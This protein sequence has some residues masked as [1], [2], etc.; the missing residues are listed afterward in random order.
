[1]PNRRIEAE[2]EGYVIISQ[3][4]AFLS[5]ADRVALEE[6]QPPPLLPLPPPE[7]PSASSAAHETPASAPAADDGEVDEWCKRHQQEAEEY[8]R[9]MQEEPVDPESGDEGQER[10]QIERQPTPAEVWDGAVTLD[11][12]FRIRAGMQRAVLPMYG[13][14]QPP[15]PGAPSIL[16][17]LRP[18]AGDQGPDPAT[19]EDEREEGEEAD[20][21]EES[22]GGEEEGD[23]E[24]GEGQE[25]RPVDGQDGI[26]H[27]GVREVECVGPVE[28]GRLFEFERCQGVRQ[29]EPGS[30]SPS[31][32]AAGQGEASD[33]SSP[34]M[35][36]AA[37]SAASSPQMPL[38]LLPSQ[39][40]AA[41]QTA[42]PAAMSQA[43]RA[44][45]AAFRPAGRYM[46]R[47]PDNNREA[48][49][50]LIEGHCDG[51]R[52]MLKGV[53][54]NAIRHVDEAIRPRISGRLRAEAEANEA[55]KGVT[56]EG[57][58][59]VT[60]EL[61]AH[62]LVHGDAQRSVAIMDGDWQAYRDGGYDSVMRPWTP[63]RRVQAEIE[64]YVIISQY[65]AFLS[66]ADR[67]ALEE[68][69]PP[70]LP[71]SPPP[72]APTASSAAHETPASAPAADDG[73]VDEWCKRYRQEVEEQERIM[74]EYMAE[75]ADVLGPD[76]LEEEPVDPESG[77]EGQE[78]QEIERK[79]TPAEVWDG[80]V[81]LQDLFHIRAGKQH[82]QYEPTA[83]RHRLQRIS[84]TLERLQLP[85][86]AY[87]GS[88]QWIDFEMARR[89]PE[90]EQPLPSLPPTPGEVD[91]APVPAPHA[92]PDAL[93]K[94]ADTIKAVISRTAT[95]SSSTLRLPF[96]TAADTYSVCSLSAA[97]LIAPHMDH[98]DGSDANA[99][100]YEEAGA[101]FVDLYDRHFKA[102]VEGETDAVTAAA[103]AAIRGADMSALA[104]LQ[105]LSG[106]G[107][108]DRHKWLLGAVQSRL[109]T[110]AAAD[111]PD[112]RASA[113]ASR[114][115]PAARRLCA[116]IAGCHSRGGVGARRRQRPRD[117]GQ[118]PATSP[119]S[120]TQVSRSSPPFY[121]CR[122]FPSCLRTHYR[123]RLRDQ[124]IDFEMA[125]R[126]SETQQPLFS[127]PSTP[128]DVDLAPVPGPHA[129]P[130]ALR[131][132]AATIEA[133]I[134]RTATTSSTTVATT[135]ALRLPFSEGPVCS[136][137]A[138]LLIAP[139]MDH[140]DGSSANTEIY[141]E[142]GAFFVESRD[143][144]A[145]YDRHFADEVVRE[146]K[147]MRTATLGGDNALASLQALSGSGPADRHKWLLGAVQ[148]RLQWEQ[149]LGEAG[150]ME[151]VKDLTM[152]KL[153][154]EEGMSLR[155]VAYILYLPA[156]FPRVSAHTIEKAWHDGDA[157]IRT[158]ASG[159]LPE[160]CRKTK[161][162]VEGRHNSMGSSVLKLD[163]LGGY[164][165]PP[166][167][168]IIQLKELTSVDKSLAVLKE[169]NPADLWRLIANKMD[170]EVDQLKAVA[171]KGSVCEM[172]LQAAVD[173]F[174][175]LLPVL[176]AT[177]NLLSEV[178]SRLPPRGGVVP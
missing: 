3:Y 27:E 23:R 29:E 30:P 16:P 170:K 60:P 128:R 158:S 172:A 88:S 68:Q 135:P 80:A 35:P 144:Q 152:A 137:S 41:A 169:V 52:V 12:V 20:D 14:R 97:L 69:Q 86:D 66:E 28:E 150:S 40:V 177:C 143:G 176:E 53:L 13:G 1:M 79:P 95:R 110:S 81:T 131:K 105:A 34:L 147:A 55:I 75:N 103:N 7:G 83:T 50:C 153:L 117:H 178:A 49:Y 62:G 133:V 57:G 136:L 84:Q 168:K 21:E 73:E 149:A 134:S 148:R 118:R 115:V 15:T 54:P 141:G 113:A 107:P 45:L 174:C 164:E 56:G 33:G 154:I 46:V 162:R 175:Q 74:R 127:L 71:P 163:P 26:V 119:R 125:R 171:N 61:I 108:A 10:Q 112:P 111:Q 31:S 32:T 101:F 140:P 94:V 100:I 145:L 142:A 5:E 109:Q 8:E 102:K 18:A 77:D 42:S 93:R 155:I 91:I 92:D 122:L 85:P 82:N 37:P 165:Q 4:I 126:R 146:T 106:S 24:A 121:I 159:A 44:S 47:L 59:P 64:G 124:W 43:S 138:A 67:V 116:V 70:R 25:G 38:A 19:E 157:L 96:S 139:H 39:A 173:P 22:G 123:V 48:Q 114:R 78:R 104:S 17:Q 120:K 98:P 58:L 51:R 160:I 65:T 76:L 129:D 36:L 63:N 72:E 87:R 166:L 130:T 161:E 99:A 132:V 11:D 6:Q 9:V 89:R 156:Y 90:T 2:I 167:H 151:A